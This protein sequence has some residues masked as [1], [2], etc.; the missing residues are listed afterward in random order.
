VD[1]HIGQKMKQ[2]ALFRRAVGDI[3]WRDRRARSRDWSRE[4]REICCADIRSNFG[5]NPSSFLDFFVLPDFY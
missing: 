5:T 3:L 4:K 2:A 1:D